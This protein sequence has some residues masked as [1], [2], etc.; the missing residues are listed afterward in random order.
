MGAKNHQ[1]WGGLWHCFTHIIDEKWSLQPVHG[2]P[3]GIET[4]CIA[5]LA[6]LARPQDPTPGH[7]RNS[8]AEVS[9]LKRT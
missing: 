5:A 2:I 4:L 8:F 7:F 1:K 6:H 3:S 9:V